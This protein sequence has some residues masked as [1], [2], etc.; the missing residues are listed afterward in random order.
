MLLTPLTGIGQY[1]FQLSRELAL[2]LPEAPWLFY[3]NHWSQELRES[4]LPA[5]PASASFKN[6]VGRIVPQAYRAARFLQQRHFTRGV[7]AHGVELYHEPNYLAFRFAGPTV[8]TVHDLSWIRYPQMHP[9][10]RVKIM[11]ETMQRVMRDASHVIVDSDFIRAEVIEHYR[12]SPLRVTSVPLGVAPEFA[13]VAREACAKALAAHG[14]RFGEYVLAVGT[15]E[16]RKNLATV[17]AAFSRLPESERKR[18]PLVVVGMHGWGMDR[19][20]DSIRDLVTRGEI[21]LMG[22]VAQSD[23]PALYSGAALFAYPSLYEGVGLPPLEAMACGAPVI[24]SDRASLPELVGDAGVIV[25][26]LDEVALEGRMRAL[27]Q[28]PALRQRLSEAGLARA[29]KFTW[30]GCAMSTLGVYRAALAS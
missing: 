11:D 3:G 25:D 24:V 4:P 27:L 12:I 23:L 7:K 15:I 8:V 14:L 28:D 16:P 5:S 17:A 13:P 21:R 22:F 2:L 10:L 1:T 9:K 18:F 30:R 20:P 6:A 26:A 19:L 29:R